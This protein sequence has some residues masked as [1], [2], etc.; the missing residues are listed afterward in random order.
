MQY[1]N[2]FSQHALKRQNNGKRNV[3]DVNFLKLK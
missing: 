2:F 1:G 3:D